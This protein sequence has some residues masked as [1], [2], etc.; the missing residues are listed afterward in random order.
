MGV[1]LFYFIYYETIFR[2]F[3]VYLVKRVISEKPFQMR[4]LYLI[5]M[6]VEYT[7]PLASFHKKG[8][9]SLTSSYFV[10][11]SCDRYRF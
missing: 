9:L 1:T 6:Q 2:R 10:M 7:Q 5:D 11:L 4:L 3:V 8:I